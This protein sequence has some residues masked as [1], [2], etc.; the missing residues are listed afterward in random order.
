[1]YVIAYMSSSDL[2]EQFGNHTPQR[3][4]SLNTPQAPIQGGIVKP[5][6]LST[7]SET[8]TINL[9]VQRFAEVDAAVTVKPVK[10]MRDIAFGVDN[11]ATSRI[12][13]AFTVTSDPLANSGAA[14]SSLMKALEAA[15]L[16]QPT[17]STPQMNS[18]PKLE[19]TSKD[20]PVATTDSQ[21]LRA[22]LRRIIDLSDDSLNEP[23][24]VFTPPIAQAIGSQDD[25]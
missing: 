17:A 11:A 1:M 19:G 9:A 8:E 7:V 22:T 5:T 21:E 2:E 10:V 12:L 16:P 6:L 18:T 4:S 23:M 13:E 24:V 14:R 20:E 25:S 15:V 3:L